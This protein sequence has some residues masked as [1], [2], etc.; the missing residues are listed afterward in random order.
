MSLDI[1][2]IIKTWLK[3]TDTKERANG[4][5]RGYIYGDLSSGASKHPGSEGSWGSPKER[6]VIG[7]VINCNIVNE[8]A[9]GRERTVKK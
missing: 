5:L 9:V 3:V 6:E 2:S 8:W 4:G 1:I 7:K